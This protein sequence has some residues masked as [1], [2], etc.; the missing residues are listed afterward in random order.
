MA[1]IVCAPKALREPELEVSSIYS[2]SISKVINGLLAIYQELTQSETQPMFRCHY[3]DG[4]SPQLTWNLSDP[5]SS[6]IHDSTSNTFYP[7]YETGTV[8]YKS[9]N[10]FKK[11][12]SRLGLNLAPSLTS[13]SVVL[14]NACIPGFVAAEIESLL[15]AGAR[16]KIHA[17][18]FVPTMIMTR[19][20][21]AE[22]KG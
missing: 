14:D 15:S 6:R 5:H 13:N 18:D 4:V 19:K 3:S 16:P 17:L 21:K 10:N 1:R 20:Q 2:C 9:I 12:I 7:H 22:A 8:T 11:E